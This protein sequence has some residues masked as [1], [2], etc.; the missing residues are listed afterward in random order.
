M[1]RQHLTPTEAQ[2]RADAILAALHDTVSG[3]TRGV[4]DQ[5]VLAL[6]DDGRPFGMND[7]RLLVP[8]DECRNAGLYFHAFTTHDQQVEDRDRYLIWCGDV[9]SINPRARGKKVGTYRLTPAGRRF[10]QERI[11]ASRQ[12]QRRAA[13]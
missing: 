4:L 11:E 10:I 12:Q 6:A 1:A 8:E 5:A 7:I 13:A 9:V 2:A 3:W